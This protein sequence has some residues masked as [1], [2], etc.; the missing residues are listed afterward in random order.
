MLVLMKSLSYI[1]DASFSDEILLHPSG[2]DKECF[3]PL[4]LFLVRS[5]FTLHRLFLLSF[6]YTGDASFS[7]DICLH[8]S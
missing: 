1:P 2:Y 6:S 4:L 7:E 8:S 5:L 3:T